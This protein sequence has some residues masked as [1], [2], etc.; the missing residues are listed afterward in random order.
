M[1][2]P[3]SSPELA[4]KYNFIRS[5]TAVDVPA[6]LTRKHGVNAGM[7]RFAHVQVIPSG[8][9]NPTVEIMWWSE[10]AAKFVKEHVALVKA[11]IG[12][13]TPFEFSIEPRGRIFAV[14]V[15]VLAAGQADIY[16]SGFQHEQV[17]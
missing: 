3:H 15:T 12:V 5:V 11:G 8:G 7:Y 2:D 13:N 9:G 10:A 4:P 14:V 17:S 1:P 16:V 6:N